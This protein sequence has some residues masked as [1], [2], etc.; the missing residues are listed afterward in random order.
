MHNLPYN[1]EYL[2]PCRHLRPQRCLVHA[3]SILRRDYGDRD[4]F[5]GAG[6]SVDGVQHPHDTE[7]RPVR[8]ERGGG[9]GRPD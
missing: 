5:V 1:N 7:D 8:G 6:D 2:N 3:D 9:R 4:R